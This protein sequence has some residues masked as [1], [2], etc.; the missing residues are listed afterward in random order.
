MYYLIRS[1]K[2]A[3]KYV[4]PIDVVSHHDAWIESD[5]DVEIGSDYDGQTFSADPQQE[6]IKLLLKLAKPVDIQDVALHEQLMTALGE[7]NV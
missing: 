5:E 1:G 6:A 7:T 3:A 4:N 2:V